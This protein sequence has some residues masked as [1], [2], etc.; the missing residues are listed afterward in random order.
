ML[1]TLAL[2]KQLHGLFLFTVPAAIRWHFRFVSFSFRFVS[3]RFVSA[4]LPC[5]CIVFSLLVFVFVM[6]VDP[7]CW[8]LLLMMILFVDF[9][10]QSLFF[11]FLVGFDRCR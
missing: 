5:C 4:L 10:L 6:T 1:F 8:S 3:F 2:D 7:A 9:A 11:S